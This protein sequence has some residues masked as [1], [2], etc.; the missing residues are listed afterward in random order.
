VAPIVI[1]FLVSQSLTL[2][3]NFFAI[4]GAIALLAVCLIS[5][6]RTSQ[7]NAVSSAPETEPI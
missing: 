4:P 7:E 1:G 2:H 5:V 3:Q 6:R